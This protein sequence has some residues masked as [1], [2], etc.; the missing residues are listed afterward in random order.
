MKDED[1]VAI[2]AA[3]LA[4]DTPELPSDLFDRAISLVTAA[5]KHVARAKETTRLKIDYEVAMSQKG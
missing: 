3:I 2:V 1:I 5:R 4:S